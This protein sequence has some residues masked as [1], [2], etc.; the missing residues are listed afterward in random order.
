ML[1]GH[2]KD[3]TTDAPEYQEG[4]MQFYKKH[5]LNLEVWPPE[6]FESMA[7]MGEDP[8]IYR[9]MLGVNEFN[10][11]GTLKDWSIIPKL[12]AVSCP[13]LIINGAD[14]EVQDSCVAPLF[15][16]IKRARWVTF[17]SSSH[18]AFWEEPEK[19]LHVVGDFLCDS[20]LESAPQAQ[21][22][23]ARWFCNSW[24]SLSKR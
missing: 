15:H 12:G 24:L 5:I 13:T 3:G 10:V 14:D 17:G 9:A 18:M 7:Q 6:T 2:E 22:I 16:G 20:G 11:T 4:L 19:Y 23:V 21:G 1:S 8:T